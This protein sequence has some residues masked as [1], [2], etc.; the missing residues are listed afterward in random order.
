EIRLNWFNDALNDKFHVNMNDDLGGMVL[1]PD[2]VGRPRG[3][4]EKCS[5]CIQ[6]T[7]AASRKAKKEG[8][9]VTDAEFQD[10]CACASACG[11]GAMVF[12]DVNDDESEVKKLSEDNRVYRVIEELGTKPNVFYHVKVKNRKEEQKQA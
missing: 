6:D 7:Q 12:G 4:M 10:A 5:F 3:V 8:R 11:T 2:E 9:R 1:T